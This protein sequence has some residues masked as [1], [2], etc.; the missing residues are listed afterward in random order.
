MSGFLIQQ[1][2]IALMDPDGLDDN[3]RSRVETR[4]GIRSGSKTMSAPS[5]RSNVVTGTVLDVPS[6]F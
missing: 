3:I 1:T 2:M 4:L 5:I 6:L